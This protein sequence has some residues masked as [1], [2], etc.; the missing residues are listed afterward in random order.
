VKLRRFIRALAGR[1]GFT[2]IELI[3]VISIFAVMAMIVAPRIGNYINAERSGLI[4]IRA[5]LSKAF[6]DAFVNG[7]TNYAVF[8]LY[9]R[10]MELSK[11]N[12]GV[13]NRSNAISVLVLGS[14]G[15]FQDS[16]HRLLKHHTFPDSFRLEEVVFSGGQTVRRGNVLVPFYPGGSSDDVVLHVLVNGTEQRTVRMYKFLKDPSVEQGYTAYE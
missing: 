12:E 11:F 10:D 7:R 16:P 15:T 3:V 1:E 6:D 8:H 4:V 13:F 2:L 5:V 9:E 14:D